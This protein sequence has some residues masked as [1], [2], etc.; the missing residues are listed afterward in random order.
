MLKIMSQD[1]ESVYDVER[2]NLFLCGNKI[3]IS[4]EVNVYQGKAA[5]LGIYKDKEEAKEVLELM[6]STFTATKGLNSNFY[7][8]K[9]P[10]EYKEEE[11]EEN[12]GGEQGETG[13]NSKV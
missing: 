10:E 7:C 3:L 13:E 5:C 12:N 1:G 11:G 9:M 6:L 2:A 4:N 8:A